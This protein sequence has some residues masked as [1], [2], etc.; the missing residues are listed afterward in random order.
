[1]AE[2]KEVAAASAFAVSL[3]FAVLAALAVL[4]FMLRLLMSGEC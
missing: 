1:M 2:V 3:L 4:T